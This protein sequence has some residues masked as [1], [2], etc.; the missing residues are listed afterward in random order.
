MTDKERIKVLDSHPGSGKTSLMIQYINELP[1][2]AKV[3]Y[4][5]P[6]LK[7]CE[8][9]QK[10]C[11]NKNF[12][13]PDSKKGRGS[14]M[15]NM[16]D[17]IQKGKSVVSTHA[18]FG[19]IDDRLIDA[20]RNHDYILILDEV[21]NVLE[22]FD[23]YKE[24]TKKTEEQKELLT[25][26][27]ISALLAKGIIS[28][29][30]ESCAVAWV[31]QD[32]ILH[33]Y[34]QIKNLA[35]R[36]MLY[37]I[38]TDLLMWSF[39]IEVFREGVFDEIYILTYQFD[40]QVQAYY[41]K[42]FNLEY[43]TYMVKETTKRKY[44]AYPTSEFPDYD[45]EWKAELKELIYIC[46]NPKL[47]KIGSYYYDA[48]DRK[49]TSAL[50]KSWYDKADKETMKVLIANITNFFQHYA[51]SRAGDRMWTCF[52]ADKPK[53]KNNTFSTKSWIELNARSTNDYA[54]KTAIAYPINRYLNPFFT[55]FFSKKGITLDQDNYAL[56]EMI[57]WIFRS[58]I[59]NGEEISLYIPSERMRNLL[60][61][62]LDE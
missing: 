60:V 44:A 40:Y 30:P 12:Y 41:Y 55:M 16:I 38:G 3:I 11:P 27:D 32:E 46:D 4:I 39:P 52:K 62:W 61:D 14:K 35:D 31:N 33:K 34:I 54:D 23:L 45:R 22:K 42:Y 9:I 20:I 15:L 51:Q 36:N 18:L 59:R 1:E 56:S 10:S 2:D 48:S 8:R 19:N 26:E 29:D 28:V 25:K 24:E 5:T 7:E 47:N 13:A 49:V 6:F 43:T 57:Q 17:L 58:A 37:L 21:M 50:C 53:F